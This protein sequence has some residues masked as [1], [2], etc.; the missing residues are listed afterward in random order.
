MASLFLQEGTTAT[1]NPELGYS[2][3]GN[4]V[5]V[6]QVTQSIIIQQEKNFLYYNKIF[7]TALDTGVITQSL[8]DDII[9]NQDS[10]RQVF[11]IESN[12][13]I[14]K[15][16]LIDLV[17]KHYIQNVNTATGTAAEI[18]EDINIEGFMIVKPI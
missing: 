12:L 6:T 10:T 17:D 3:L 9:N 18:V 15:Q 14:D 4:N 16:L 7:Q 11:E 5:G 1:V 2:L 8:Y 13:I